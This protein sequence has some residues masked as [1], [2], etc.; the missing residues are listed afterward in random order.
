[1]QNFFKS[2]EISI[3]DLEPSQNS[4]VSVQ[5]GNIDNTLNDVQNEICLLYTSMR[6]RPQEVS[7]FYRRHQRYTRQRK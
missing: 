7:R 5:P 3:N 6:K 2:G 4:Y 1:M